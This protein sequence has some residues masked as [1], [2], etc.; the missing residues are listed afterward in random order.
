MSSIIR[1]IYLV[2]RVYAATLHIEYE[3]FFP[4]DYSDIVT[5]ESDAADVKPDCPGF[6]PKAQFELKH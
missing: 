2:F 3:H 4:E 1:Q 6:H 5:A